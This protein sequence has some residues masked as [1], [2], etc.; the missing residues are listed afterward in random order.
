MKNVLYFLALLAIVSGCRKT[1]PPAP[2]PLTEVVV[3]PAEALPATADDPTWDS[4]PEFVAPLILQDLVEPRLMEKSTPEV[5]VRAI[6]VGDEVAFRL[7]WSDP[8]DS[9]MA[10]PG[11]FGDACAIQVPAAAGGGVPAPQMGEPGRPVEIVLWSAVWQAVVDGRGDTIRDIYPRASIDHYPFNAASLEPG[12]AD[13]KAMAARY[14]PARAL[15]NLMA[16]PRDNPVQALTAEGPGTLA[17]N[18]T[19][20]ASGRGARTDEGWAVVVRRP[21]PTGLTPQ[22]GTQIAFAVWEGSH[23]E[24][25]ARKMRTGWVP[26]VLKENP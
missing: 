3:V 5:R 21:L 16:G 6:A 24:V 12:S 9:N 14:A 1:P 8:T 7:A 17:P 4:V 18:K 20:T 26:L 15:G 19:L 10:T 22:N 2:A 11:L 13:Q 23:Q 25:G